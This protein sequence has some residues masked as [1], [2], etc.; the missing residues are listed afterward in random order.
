M[1]NLRQ[2]PAHSKIT[3][4]VEAAAEKF[5]Q[6]ADAVSLGVGDHK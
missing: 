4:K 6:N 5:G 3:A 2:Q 1:K